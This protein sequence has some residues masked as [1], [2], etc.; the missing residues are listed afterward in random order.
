[1]GV[2][3]DWSEDLLAPLSSAER[4]DI[5]LNL[6]HPK[7]KEII[8]NWSLGPILWRRVYPRDNGE[9]GL[10]YEDLKKIKPDIIML[11]MHAWTNRAF[12]E[13]SRARPC[14]HRPI[15]FCFNYRLA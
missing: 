11:R 9:M 2:S 14:P 6:N 10:G 15:R 8:K 7:A 3:V 4:L 1:M 5:T 13:T 12:G